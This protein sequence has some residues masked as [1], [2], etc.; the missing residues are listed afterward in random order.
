MDIVMA[1]RLGGRRRRGL[2]AT[3]VRLVRTGVDGLDGETG[4]AVTSAAAAGPATASTAILGLGE[5]GQSDAEPDGEH[6]GQSER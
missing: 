3:T 5:A 4:I 1:G 2:A 6:A